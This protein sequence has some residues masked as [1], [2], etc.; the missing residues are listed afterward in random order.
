LQWLQVWNPY[1]NLKFETLS[2]LPPLSDEQIAKQVE[3]MIR[4]NLIPCLEFDKV[5]KKRKEKKTKA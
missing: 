3:F 4:Q 1:N 5:E 2:Y